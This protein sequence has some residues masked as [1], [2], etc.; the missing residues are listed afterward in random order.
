MAHSRNNELDPNFNFVQVGQDVEMMGDQ[1][2]QCLNE[3]QV[4]SVQSSC[5]SIS[6]TVST[7]SKSNKRA[8]TSI[9]WKYFKINEGVNSKDK[10]EEI[11][12]CVFCHECC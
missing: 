1:Y 9:V 10:K 11:A 4:Q 12:F 2:N 8:K 7:S 5:A 6:T 3:S